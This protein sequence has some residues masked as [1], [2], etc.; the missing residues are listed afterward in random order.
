MKENPDEIKSK[1]HNETYIDLLIL[2]IE[3]KEREREKSQPNLSDNFANLFGICCSCS[4]S[5]ELLVLYEQIGYEAIIYEKRRKRR[6]LLIKYID[7]YRNKNESENVSNNKKSEILNSNIIV[8]DYE[9]PKFKKSSMKL[10]YS[11]RIYYLLLFLNIFF[12]GVG[13]IIAA[14]GWGNTCKNKN[15]TKELLLR[16]ILQILTSI[17]IIGWIQSIFDAINYFAIVNIKI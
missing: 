9:L 15:R 2:G 6:E 13:T 5:K 16:G 12:P 10:C 7:Y 4:C 8:N 11:I 1:T 17:F 14:I 3:K